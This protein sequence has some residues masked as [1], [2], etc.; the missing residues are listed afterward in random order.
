[1]ITLGRLFSHSILVLGLGYC[2]PCIE[3]P[4]PVPTALPSQ[5]PS[6]PAPTTVPTI[7]PTTDAPSS[8]P[9]IDPLAGCPTQIPC[10]NGEGVLFCF[11]GGIG[12]AD[13]V[14]LCVPVCC[15]SSNP[16]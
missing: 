12:G 15:P 8:L 2:G 4:S 14:E 7:V 9:T 16:V 13:S 11:E 6:D 10:D 5:M 1:M 3:P